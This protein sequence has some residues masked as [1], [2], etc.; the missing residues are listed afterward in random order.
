MQEGSVVG[1]FTSSMWYF[2]NFS[3]FLVFCWRIRRMPGRRRPWLDT[4]RASRLGSRRRPD[5]KIKTGRKKRR[6]MRLMSYRRIRS[7]FWNLIRILIFGTVFI[8]VL[9]TRRCTAIFMKNLLISSIFRAYWPV[10]P[11]IDSIGKIFLVHILYVNL[12]LKY[13]THEAVKKIENG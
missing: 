8:T 6:L 9:W 13:S 12:I 5:R 10:K 4:K 2:K 7:S 3:T 1:L 11:V